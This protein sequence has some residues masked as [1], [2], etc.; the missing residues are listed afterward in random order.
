M[1][2]IKRSPASPKH[3]LLFNISIDNR[4][5][6]MPISTPSIKKAVKLLCEAYSI[7]PKELT[8]HFV[9]EKTIAKLH[10]IYFNDGSVTDCITFPCDPPD[11]NCEV[12]GEIF[13]CPKVALSYAQKHGLDPQK[14]LLLY[15]VHGFL[16]LMGFD[17]LTAK[18]RRKMRIQEKKCLKILSVKCS[19]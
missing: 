15:L 16:H 19:S 5:R 8:I 1:V 12:L 14:E 6:T 2:K 3:H 13:I 11:E 10:K 7:F 4:Q 17:D 18:E 9:S